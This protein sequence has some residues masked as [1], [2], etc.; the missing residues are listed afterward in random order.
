MSQYREI[1]EAYLKTLD[2]K[3]DRVLDVGGASNP[4]N[5]RV[6]N[7]VVT[8]YMIA[9]NGLEEGDYDYV[10]DLNEY[11]CYPDAFKINNNFEEYP[12]LQF[13]V[14]FCLEVMEYI[15]N[16]VDAIYNLFEMLKKGGTLYI[17]FPTTYPVHNPYN[18][19]YLRYTKFGAIKLLEEAG[20]KIEEII[21][22]TMKAPDIYNT[23]CI[24]EGY[25]TRGASSSGTLFDAGYIFKVTKI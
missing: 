17:T 20:F 24:A 4:V 11:P 1:L 14:M 2:I 18:N 9:D 10:I 3:A 19:D 7:F 15:Y 21:P 25:K 12:K 6:N 5:V 13:N 23:S 22:R 16:P 8:D